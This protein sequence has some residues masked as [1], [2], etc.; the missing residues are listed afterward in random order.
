[1]N[2]RIDHSNYEAWLLDRLEGE[3]TPAQECELDAF[4][5]QHP[6]LAPG[7]DALPSVLAI[8]VALSGVEKEWLK[9]RIPPVAAVAA[10]SVDLHLVARLEDDLTP[11]QLAALRLFLADH[12]EHQRAERIYALTKLVPEA[13]IYAAK[14]ELERHFPPQGMPTAFNLDDL[15]VARLEGDLTMEQ[16]RAVERFLTQDKAYQRAWALMQ[17]TRYSKAP[18]VFAEKEGLKKK[19]ARVIP[20]TMA[21]W[22]VRLAAAASVALLVGLGLWLLRSPD[23]HEREIAR[24]PAKRVLPEQQVVQDEESQPHAPNVPA[25]GE[26]LRVAPSSGMN[27]PRTPAALPREQPAIPARIDPV[28][29]P[30]L[31]QDAPSSAPTNAPVD[32]PVT[33]P[34]PEP[35][36]SLASVPTTKT[37]ASSGGANTTLGELLAATVRD[38]VLE[39]PVREEQTL[40]G[41]DAIAMVDRTLKVVGGDRAGLDVGR[42]A[43]D[44]SRRFDLRLGRNFS[45]SR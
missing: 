20:F 42:K 35:N 41:E 7:D 14:G 33:P 13:T 36:E 9:K 25:D 5:L 17:A 24:V 30:V 8:N 29:E 27:E 26:Q 44:G 10:H 32:A 3:L 22:A 18:V 1:L 21:T 45:I 2:E 4:L 12:P 39:R 19:E 11:D 34:A 28:D 31:A 15:L 38:R 23:V 37:S 43:N 16:E 6:H 40:D